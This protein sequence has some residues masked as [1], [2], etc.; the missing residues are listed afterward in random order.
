MG[1][2]R[3]GSSS[4]ERDL[5]VLVD[6]KLNMN[7][8]SA[9]V[10]KKVNR[11][12]GCIDKGIPTR[13]K[14]VFIPLYSVLIRPHLEYCVQSWSPP[15]KKDVG[16]LER[17]QRKATKMIKGL[18]KLPCKER[19]RELGSFSLEKRRLK[20]HLYHHVE[21]LKGGYEEDE[22]SLFTRS[23]MEKRRGNGY[24]L[25][26]GRF[27]LDTS[28][29]FFTMRTTSHWNNLPREVVD[30]LS[31]DT[32]KIQLDRVLAHLVYTVLL[33]RKVGADDP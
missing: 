20:G 11:M 1:S 27:Q 14:E 21:Y 3:L 26:L 16:R 32:F 33:P 29:K 12:L 19:L 18:G 15:Y 23:H 8:Q 10:A 25:L 17:I 30:S 22:D 28:G 5:G 7:E 4:V 31:L 2:T 9:T 24:E 6:N 13:D